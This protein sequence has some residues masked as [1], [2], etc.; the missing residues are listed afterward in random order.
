MKLKFALIL[1]CLIS[2][3]CGKFS[4]KH[5]YKIVYEGKGHK[6][7]SVIPQITFEDHFDNDR[8]EF[9]QNQKKLIDKRIT[10]DDR[11]GVASEDELSINAINKV[12]FKINNDRLVTMD[13]INAYPYVYFSKDIESDTFWITYSFLR[14]MYQ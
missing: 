14:R 10:T 9:F 7:T 8:I 4:R 12:Y 11:V 3:Q 2:I 13:S 5:I 6:L 1:I